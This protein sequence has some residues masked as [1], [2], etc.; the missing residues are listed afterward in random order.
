MTSTCPWVTIVPFCDGATE[1][2][3]PSSPGT[4]ARPP[5]P[6]PGSSTPEFAEAGNSPRVRFLMSTVLVRGELL[7]TREDQTATFLFEGDGVAIAS[8]FEVDSAVPSVP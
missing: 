4:V 2:P 8:A 1:R 6:K 5:S 7:S 3:T